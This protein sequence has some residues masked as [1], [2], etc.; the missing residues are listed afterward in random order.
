MLFYDAIYLADASDT[1]AFRSSSY[2]NSHTTSTFG[3][4]HI[5]TI[6]IEAFYDLHSISEGSFG[7]SL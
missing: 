2:S 7:V 6:D 3:T 4:I 5:T 1:L